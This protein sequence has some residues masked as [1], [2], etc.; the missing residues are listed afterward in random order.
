[1]LPEAKKLTLV[2]FLSIHGNEKGAREGG[3][4]VI[5]DF[6]RDIGLVAEEPEL[7]AMLD[8]QKLVFIFP[9][10]DG[11]THEE[12]T[13]RVANTDDAGT[14]V[15]ALGQSYSRENARFTDLNRQ[16]PTVGY[17]FEGYTPLSEPESQGI[18]PYTKSLTNVVAGADMHGMPQN[19]NLVRMLLKDGEKDQQQMF[20]NERIAE[21]YK[22]RLNGNPH[23]AAWDTA[24]EQSG[25][26]C[27]QVAEWAATFD[28]IGYSAS[29]T[30]GAWIV[31][32]QGL[33]APGYTVEFAYN[34]I[35]FD[36]Y[37]PGAGASFNDY[38]VEA[39]RDIVSVFMNFAAEKVRLSV[40]THGSR[41]AVLTSPYVATNS[42]DEVA[43]EGWPAQNPLDDAFDIA[44]NNF[45]ATPTRYWE[46]LQAYVRNGELPG[47]LD[48]YEDSGR[49]IAALTGYDAAVIPG[50]AAARLTPGQATT[51]RTW[52]ENGG[53]LILTDDALTLLPALGLVA[54][55][56]V[57]NKTA[58]SGY[59]DF[60]NRDHPITKDLRGFPRQTYD[61]N[62]LGFAP[63]SSPVV[64]VD[65]A[66]WEDAGGITLG[67]AGKQGSGEAITEDPSSCGSTDLGTLTRAA[68]PAG[69]N[70]GSYHAWEA[71]Q[72]AGEATEM[73]LLAAP[74]HTPAAPATMA[75]EYGADCQDL[76]A[77]VIG[78][79]P[80]G[81]GRVMILG[82]ILP[83]PSEAY[84]HPYGLDNYALSPNGNALILNMLG[85]QYTYTTPPAIE[86]RGFARE[87]AGQEAIDA[88][89]VESPGDAATPGPTAL[90]TSLAIA[91]T[92]LIV[93]RRRR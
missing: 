81:S 52:V 87:L 28:A 3:L 13:N 82:A 90:I 72:H 75:Y 9:N 45:T 88:A 67:A 51:L 66:A 30:A 65:R 31:Q 20:E 62:P 85:W 80:L 41:A 56:D 43:L 14:N 2:F 29:A 38:H 55:A 17:L 50:S 77:T 18:V 58:Y 19:T 46:D 91:A 21:L 8:Y 83:D 32:R 25:Y 42:D 68:P 22:E 63:G 84:N 78:E 69:Y 76:D 54:Q 40:E 4:R 44:H 47:I 15:F 53:A 16:F 71:T 59:A 37:Y 39:T 33:D 35:T 86:E 57:G 6:A 5:E 93:A 36:N 48:S 7:A 92:A 1:L 24:P 74:V 11:W 70:P 26:C 10:P 61:P 89:N 64:W 12:G 60:V 27:G 49:F 34:H 79:A 73:P 23:Y